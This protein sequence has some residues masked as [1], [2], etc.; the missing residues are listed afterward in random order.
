MFHVLRYAGFL[1]GNPSLFNQSQENRVRL[2]LKRSSSLNFP[3]LKTGSSLS[4]PPKWRVFSKFSFLRK[5]LL[6][7]W[8]GPL[9]S[10]SNLKFSSQVYLCSLCG[11]MRFGKWEIHTLSWLIGQVYKPSFYFTIYIQ[12]CTGTGLAGEN[13]RRDHVAFV[14][15]FSSILEGNHGYILSDNVSLSD[16]LCQFLKHFT[17][18]ALSDCSQWD[19]ILN[20]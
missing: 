8:D 6:I 14:L 16:I 12:I 20:V 19:L 15:E 5:S 7:K 1:G 11:R 18:L 10:S 17:I 4:E 2:D 3:L 13:R 9:L